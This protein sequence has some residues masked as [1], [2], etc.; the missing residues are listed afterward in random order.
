MPPFLRGL[1]F[2][3]VVYMSRRGMNESQVSLNGLYTQ[4]ASWFDDYTVLLF[5]KSLFS[6]LTILI[7]IHVEN[8]NECINNA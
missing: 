5:L 4:T 2:Y 3:Q 6:I 8:L 7:P 1:Y